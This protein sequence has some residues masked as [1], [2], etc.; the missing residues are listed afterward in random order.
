MIPGG[1][2]QVAEWS[3]ARAWKV[4]IRQKRIVGSNPTLSASS[5][6]RRALRPTDRRAAWQVSWG[7]GR[8]F[9]Q[10]KSRTNVGLL[11]ADNQI[12]LS[13]I[14]REPQK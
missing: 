14:E 13:R 2:G 6:T 4:R 9:D 11:P 5:H 3:M 12:D 7:R 8:A 10:V 1:D